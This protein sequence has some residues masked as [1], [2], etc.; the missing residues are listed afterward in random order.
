MAVSIYFAVLLCLNQSGLTS[1]GLHQSGLTSPGLH[2]SGLI[3]PA[4]SKHSIYDASPYNSSIRSPSITST[5]PATLPSTPS[6]SS[7]A[8]ATLSSAPA[9]SSVPKNFCL[10]GDNFPIEGVKDATFY[11]NT[12]LEVAVVLLSQLITAVGAGVPGKFSLVVLDDNNTQIAFMHLPDLLP[13]SVIDLQRKVNVGFNQ[14]FL[15]YNKV[16]R[17]HETLWISKQ[18]SELPEHYSSKCGVAPLPSQDSV[19][20]IPQSLY[21]VTNIPKFVHSR[22][23]MLHNLNGLAVKNVAMDPGNITCYCKIHP[24]QLCS[25]NEPRDLVYIVLALASRASVYV[26]LSGGAMVTGSMVTG[27]LVTV[28]INTWSVSKI[29]SAPL[30][31]DTTLQTH[32]FKPDTLYLILIGRHESDIDC[33]ASPAQPEELTHKTKAEDDHIFLNIASSK[34]ETYFVYYSVDHDAAKIT[35]ETT[36]SEDIISHACFSTANVSGCVELVSY[37]SVDKVMFTDNHNAKVP[38]NSGNV[39]IILNKCDL[40]II[41]S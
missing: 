23:L 20:N 21:S 2:Q 18:C 8:P 31:R 27:D 12:A 29:I 30:N 14:T 24:I 15:F 22:I 5:N 16:S 1:P 28:T 7:S 40:S 33:W 25:C 17:K 3:S 19:I 10:P 11:T 37:N 39:V 35:I 9:T 26:E 34:D 13:L 38:G 41:F 36:N 32:V 6:T 4:P